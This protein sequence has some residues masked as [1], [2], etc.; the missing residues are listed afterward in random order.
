MTVEGTA[1]CDPMTDSG[2]R[3]GIENDLDE[4]Q[5]ELIAKAVPGGAQNIQDIYPLLPLQEGILFHHLMNERVDTY[6]LSLLFQ[7]N[8]RHDVE[9]L[10]RAIQLVIDRHEI[11][12]VFVVWDG[13]PRPVQ[14]VCH[15][16]TLH[17]EEAVL[18]PQPDAIEQVRTWMKPTGL[19]RDLRKAP[20]IW[21]QVAEDLREGQ[22]YAVLKVHHLICDHQSL[23]LVVA[24]VM[25]LMQGHGSQLPAPVAF[26]RHVV[27]AFEKQSTGDTESFFRRKLNDI[28]EPSA[29]FGM[30]DVYG[31]GS[32]IDETHGT[33]DSGLV[34]LIRVQARRYGVSAARIFHAAWGLVVARTSGRED[35]VFGTVVLAARQ[36]HAHAERMLGLS[37][38]T[39]PLRLRLQNVTSGELV[40]QTHLE[41]TELVRHESAPLTLAQRCSSIAGTTPLF[42]SLLNFRHS[43]SDA[44]SASAAGVRVV[45]RG[46][47]WT[48]YPI[49][50]T[51]DDLG[52]GF[53]LM[54]KVDRRIG[55]HRMLDCLSTALESLCRAL[56][57][58]P[59]T[60][61]LELAVLP[62]GELRDIVEDWGA[63]SA[64]ALPNVLLHSLF[65]AE[66]ERSPDTLAVSDEASSLSYGELNSRSNRLAHFLRAKGVGPDQLVALCLER[67]VHM[68]VGVLGV[69]KAGGAYIPVD[70]ANPV[71]RVQHILSDACPRLVLT[72]ESLKG[73]LN[74]ATAEVIALD[75]A[76]E[77]ADQSDC[78]LDPGP[79]GLS[80]QNLAYV[81]YTSGSTGK[82]KGVMV[83][84]RSVVN[85]ALF[86]IRKFDVSAGSGSVIGTSLSF[87]LG[88]TGLYPTLLCGRPVRLCSD[89][90]GIPS[91]AEDVARSTNLSPLKVTPSH[92]ALLQA[93]LQSGQ[94]A[95]RVRVLVMGGEALHAAT[96]RLWREHA[97]G[98]R[99][100]NHYGPTETTI[101]CLV[102]E[103]E[104]VGDGVVPLGR[105]I[106]NVQVYVLDR[107]LQIAPIGAAGE[108]HVGGVG[109]TRGYLG[110]PELTAERFIADP[111]S[112]NPRSR[113]YKTGDI[114][115]WRADGVVEY[116]G[117]NDH[118]VKIRGYRI[119]LGEIEAE[120]LRQDCV[121]EAVV[122]ARNDVP[123]GG[124]VAY[125]TL[126]EESASDVEKLPACLKARLPEYMVPNAVVVLK[127]LPLTPNGKL[128]RRALPAP[129][130]ATRGLY[131]APQGELEELVAEL[132]QE[133][134]RV[135]R[136]SR[137]D[138]FFEIGGHS[139]LA[140]R[141]V[142]RIREIL[143]VEL[144]LRAIFDA[145]TLEQL[146]L[147]IVAEAGQPHEA[148]GMDILIGDLRSEINGMNDDEVLA[149]ISR[150]ERELS[151]TSSD[152]LA[153]RAED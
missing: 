45:A 105:P 43:V 139:L 81:I 123:G 33:I 114:G 107:N 31:D 112:S 23:R 119:E 35:V 49:T 86:A 130:M 16:A 54:A 117:R 62:V 46:E 58:A 110:R 127:S 147:R 95:N 57:R 89:E 129:D 69:L 72:Q 97:P 73:R 101:G 6:V 90:R 98:T 65:E 63:G 8:I 32:Q 20:L 10:I 126:R 150:L 121:K 137:R 74:G 122:I 15:Q 96:V 116:L 94:L 92:L 87:D 75:S 120:L 44:E 102:N 125:I 132:W 128:D 93:P 153:V 36:R 133:L 60:P 103:L 144:P 11:L 146:A 56:E 30:V 42:T 76:R 24:E 22:W 21:L 41:L 26:R 53:S 39:L 113:M 61:A 68:L 80:A 77:L 40:Q 135:D 1:F 109:V 51:V 12:R 136:V 4:G 14:V 7:L 100:F 34:N 134:L 71:E 38:N 108:I 99:L 52:D 141:I 152:A 78:N 83:E 25:A 138:N 148:L 91:L 13:L 88:L 82:P 9:A 140:A 47:A 67:N 70:P 104:Q 151:G 37:V 79:I 18:D 2:V 3:P 48:N 124:L 143:Q 19:R 29:P 17:V 106:D 27:E 142:W 5:L 66:A 50:M 131:E 55:A 145:P 84:H 149:R 59:H 111:F 118:Q 64:S 85:Y 115:R 28:D